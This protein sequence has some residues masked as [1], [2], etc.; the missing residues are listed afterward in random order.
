[1]PLQALYQRP[2]KPLA[3]GIKGELLAACADAQAA[4]NEAMHEAAVNAAQAG[5]QPQQLQVACT[6]PCPRQ[7]V[8][9]RGCPTAHRAA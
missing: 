6:P 2:L 4:I 7:L 8:P 9:V 1:M 5:Q 3:G